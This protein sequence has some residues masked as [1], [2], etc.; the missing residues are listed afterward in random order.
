[1]TQT[2]NIS[3][4]TA[5]LIDEEIRG[6]I[7]AGEAT[8]KRIL[9]EKLDAL[10]AVAK[11]LLEFETLNGDEVQAIMRGEK[12]VRRS[13]DEGTKGPAGSAVPAAGRSR[14]REEPD[15]GSMEPQ[16]QS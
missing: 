13:D 12:I 11:A 7:Q 14:P 9:T 4:Q 16:P 8:A 10:H 2:K 6:L 5:K 1:V 15:A 3:D